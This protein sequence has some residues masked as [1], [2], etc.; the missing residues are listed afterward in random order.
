MRFASARDVHANLRKSRVLENWRKFLKDWVS[1]AAIPSCGPGALVL[2]YRSNTDSGKY[3]N[4]RN[5]H[6]II[7]VLSHLSHPS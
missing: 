2:L 7:F 3:L 5:K 1:Q 4:E 6:S